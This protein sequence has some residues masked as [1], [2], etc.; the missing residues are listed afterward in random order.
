AK[1]RR[2][3]VIFIGG[4]RKQATSVVDAQD[5]FPRWDCEYIFSSFPSPSLNS[6]PPKPIDSVAMLV[7][8]GKER[9]VGQVV[10]PLAEIADIRTAPV[11]ITSNLRIADLQPTKHNSCPC[12]QL[13]FWIWVE[14]LWPE[15]TIPGGAKSLSGSHSFKGSLSQL[16]SAIKGQ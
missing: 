4:E 14:D 13:S 5:G 7:I 16:G 6:T 15:G 10:V 1:T 2:W 12:G 3:R 11:L 8:D 9:H